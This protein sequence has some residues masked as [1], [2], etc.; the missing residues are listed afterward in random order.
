MIKSLIALALLAVSALAFQQPAHP[1]WEVL[2][3]YGPYEE[4]GPSSV[5]RTWIYGQ[6]C[7]MFW[8]RFNSAAPVVIHCK[9]KDTRQ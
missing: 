3:P 2:T 8:S 9:P 5:I 1:V 4:F 6:D 7:L